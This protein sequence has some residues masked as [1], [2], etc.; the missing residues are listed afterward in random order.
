MAEDN[1]LNREIVTEL[2]TEQG[3]VITTAK[4]GEEAVRLFTEAATGTYDM[5]LMDVMMPVMNGLEAAQ[6][7]RSMEREDAGTIPI[8]A[9][10]AN[11]FSEDV[12][13]SRQAGMSA[14]MTKPFQMEEML[15]KITELTGKN[16]QKEEGK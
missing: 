2:L 11:A 9:L 13:K 3:A 8:V 12:E 7:I 16:R 10:T 15:Q 4:N 1:E 5:I 14:H 6:A